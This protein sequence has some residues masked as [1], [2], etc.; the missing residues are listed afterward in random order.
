MPKGSIR[1]RGKKWYYRFFE[2]GKVIERCGGDKK[3]DALKALN[4]EL[5][6]KYK[7]YTRPEET[8]LKD[9]LNM[10]L[11]NYILDEKSENT[12]DK[13][14]KVI[15]NK[16]IPSIG[17][18]RLCDLKAIHV[19]KFL[20]DLKKSKI[21]K[22]KNICHLSGTTI[23]MYYGILNAALNRAVKLQ[24]II[25]N[26]CKYIDTPKRNKYKASILTLQEFRLIYNSLNDTLFEDYIFKLALDISIETGLRRGELCGLT[27]D[28]INFEDNFIDIN[29]SLIRIEN[30]YSISKLKTEGSYRT[31]PI[32]DELAQKLKKHKTIQSSNKLK[33]GEFYK[34]VIFNKISYDLIFR[35]ENGDYIIPS[36]FLQRLKRLCRYNKI[37]KNIRWHDLRHT[38][39]TYLIES[40]V[41]LKV[42]QDRLG[43][44]LMQTTAD[45]YSHVTKKMNREATTKL[46]SL[47]HS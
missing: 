42:V 40:G 20:R 34:K 33:Y 17:D 24:M 3:E 31:I 47:I 18:I 21:K 38:N 29:K 14:N 30:Q 13:Y 46:T 15:T 6:R 44:S 10:W 11:E 37:D 28:S 27:W 43:H 22:G 7:G 23:Q 41:N 1:Q 4:E 8:K 26:P 32:S 35:H 9:Y 16:I 36:T 2:D 39:A 19:D 5:N 25:E 45:T 12:Y